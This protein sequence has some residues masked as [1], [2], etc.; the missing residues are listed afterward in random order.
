MSE[1]VEFVK[2][3]IIT[4]ANMCPQKAYCSLKQRTKKMN[5]AQSLAT[6]LPQPNQGIGLGFRV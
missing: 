3:V 6:P 2:F 5:L 4:C 1:H